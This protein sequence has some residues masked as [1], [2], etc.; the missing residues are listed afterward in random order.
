M[1]RRNP[2]AAVFVFTTILGAGF[3][4][5]SNN[6]H[7]ESR[8]AEIVSNVPLIVVHKTTVP[9]WLE[10]VGTVR[11][12]QT[13]QVASQMTGNVR[14]IRVHEGDRVQS[15]QILATIDDSQPRAAADQAAAALGAAQKEVSAADSDLALA[16]STRNRYQQLYDKKSISPQEFDEIKAREQSAEARRDMARAGEAQANAALAQARASLAYASIHAPFSGVVTQKYAD[17]GTL[18]STGAP[19]FTIDG[20]GNYRLEVTVD[21]DDIRNVRSGQS[22]TVL[23]DALGN[24]ELSGKVVEIVPAADPSSRT[25]LVKIGLPS[26]P[27]IHSGIFGRAR[28]SKGERQTLLIPR[29]AIV[30]HGQLQEIYVADSNRLSGLRYVTLGKIAGQQVEVLS[31]LQDGE[32]IVADPGGR[33]LGGKQIASQQ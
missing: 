14:E 5:C 24:A 12:S 18:A 30:E 11:A 6:Q 33:D 26:N 22:A 7:P 31:G 4:G 3:S 32:T 28:F 29:K 2:E 20:T 25:F 27:Q 9:D 8:A 16:E 1:N 23:F 13:I 19:L 10:A 15:G 21:E 17:P